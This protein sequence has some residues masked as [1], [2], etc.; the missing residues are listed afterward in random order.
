MKEESRPSETMPPPAVP[1]KR[2][3]LSLEEMIEKRKAE[4]EALSKPKFLTKAERAEIALKKRQEQVEEQRKK[5][6]EARKANAEFIN[7]DAAVKPDERDR[8]RDRDRDQYRDRADR[9]REREKERDRD[10]RD[11]SDKGSEVKLA[12]DKEKEQNAIKVIN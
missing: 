8:Y 3:P 9:D 2:V 7:K 11:R 6:E 4:E 5:M 10:R 12:G 1:A